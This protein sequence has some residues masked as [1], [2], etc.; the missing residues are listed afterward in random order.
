MWGNQH[1]AE[2]DISDPNNEIGSNSHN[3][4]SNM[5]ML[6]IKV[7][8]MVESCHIPS[9]EYISYTYT[10]ETIENLLHQDIEETDRVPG[11]TDF[12]TRHS[13]VVGTFN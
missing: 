5:A 13:N 1:L 2:L 8:S 3:L 9:P 11:L 10:T 6:I 4:S 12:L 7:D